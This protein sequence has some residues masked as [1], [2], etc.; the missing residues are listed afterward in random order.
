[1]DGN[2]ELE[3]SVIGA[4]CID[5]SVISV[6]S[7][8]LR[9]ED[10]ESSACAAVFDAAVDA[11]SRGKL[12]DAVIAA[13]TLKGKIDNERKFI[14]DCMDLCPSVTSAEYHAQIIR[15]NADGRTLEKAIRDELAIGGDDLA[16]RIAAI[17]NDQIKGRP[18][19]RSHTFKQTIIDT[20]QSLFKPDGQRV[21]TGYKILDNYVKGMRG[22]ELVLLAARPGVGKSA[23]ALSIAIN[24]AKTGREV[25]IFSLEMGY[26]EIGERAISS[27]TTVVTMEDIID[28][29]LREEDAADIAKSITDLGD[30]PI[31][32]NDS[33]SVKPSFVRSQAVTQKDLGLIIVD[34]GG[35]MIPDRKQESRNLELGSI[36]RDLK[37]MAMELDVP[38]I[39]LA[40]LN[41]GKG[42][43]EEP[44]L[45][46][47]RDS[48]E[49][50]QNANKV[51]F[52]WY[53][54]KEDKVVGV[55]CAKNRRGKTGVVQ[56]I[57]N[58]DH[59]RFTET[60]EK[61]EPKKRRTNEPQ[62]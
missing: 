12:F 40:Q 24:V 39:M 9:P 35:L 53:I 8:I 34:Y 22:G 38:I 5:Q 51:I 3:Y 54:D 1:M 37:T 28:R 59:M 13:D 44:N 48:G 21:D 15:K 61:Y 60:E 20:Y 16:E 58:G 42:E 57:F 41:R 50:E 49:L 4:I 11:D 45:T 31:V 32:I 33:P 47:L 7:S 14:A 26:L 30:L 10:F 27:K 62:L 23:M 18:G 36:S 43:T 19:N 46:E 2:Y 55:K 6:L 56:M 25:L 29:D 17:C 52:L